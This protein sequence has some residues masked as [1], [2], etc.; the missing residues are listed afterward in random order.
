MI[1]QTSSNK[2]LNLFRRFRSAKSSSKPERESPSA[3]KRSKKNLLRN[4]FRRFRVVP[5]SPHEDLEY[6]EC[7]QQF[8]LLP[9]P[10]SQQPVFQRISRKTAQLGTKST[11]GS[12]NRTTKFHI[13][14]VDFSTT[15]RES[16]GTTHA[17][18][19]TG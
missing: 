8:N 3:Q 18:T 1:D 14:S 9:S 17:A 6:V 4:R 11:L 15:E 10:R 2:R 16:P 19:K 12:R 7:Q 5:D 13:S